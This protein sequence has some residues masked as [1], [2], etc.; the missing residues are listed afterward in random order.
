MSTSIQISAPGK[1]MLLGEHAV[2]YNRPCLVSAVDQRM[3]VTLELTTRDKFEL[4]AEDVNIKNYQKPLS[5]IGGGEIPKGA[6]FAE[7]AV[8]NFCEK[9]Q[10][11]KGIKITTQSQFSSLFGFG[12]SSAVTVCVIK[13]LSEL[14]K[15]SLSEK[16]VFDLSYK[17][18]LDIQGK[19]SGF[20][21][22]AA[23]Y[24]GTLYF[25]TGG[26]K[27][28]PLDTKGLELVVGYS[29]VKADTVTMVNLVKEKM[30][31]QKKVI[32]KIFDYIAQLVEDARDAILKKDWRYL[33]T[34]MDYNQN[35]LEELG[36]ST[37]KLNRMI[38]AARKTG[39]YGAKLS[40]AGGGD[41]M[42]ALVSKEKQKLVQ[43]AIQN[44]GGQILELA[45]EAEG[46][47]FEE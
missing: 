36:V 21:L 27:M 35:Y 30:I 13:G 20:D 42:I 7:M 31:A 32:E 4:N 47:R 17:T 26:K 18:I 41:C 6:S 28:E 45:I 2:V 14:T 44:N 10:L 43:E 25:V 5:E 34:L 3:H 39:A 23:I 38:T 22:A 16:E 46:V 24:G 12:S 11:K 33:G 29:G 8:K 9:Y 15:I 1:L 40:G 37:E 19:G